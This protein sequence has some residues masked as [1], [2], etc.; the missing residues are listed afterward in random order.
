[1]NAKTPL[2]HHAFIASHRAEPES[3]RYV[4]RYLADRK[5]WCDETYRARW[6]GAA[7]LL[8]WWRTLDPVVRPPLDD[9]KE[10][11][12]RAFLNYLERQGLARSTVK[13]YR[14]GAAALTSALRACK[15]WPVA[16]DQSYAPFSNVYPNTLKRSSNHLP[17]KSDLEVRFSSVTSPLARARLGLLL[18]LMALGMSLPEV[19]SR[20]WGD[21]NQ[22]DRLIVGYRGRVLKYGVEVVAALETL[23]ALR[24]QVYAGQRLLGWEANTARR[25]LNFLRSCGLKKP[26]D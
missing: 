3:A 23:S 22:A 25:W 24:P 8:S 10:D 1:M 26:T 16:F 9:L 7:A 6:D 14:T 21:I 20:R 18:A 12:A 5:R 17:S 15:T 11:D 2:H 4:L 13:G 19:C